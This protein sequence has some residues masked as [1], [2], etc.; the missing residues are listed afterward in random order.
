MDKTPVRYTGNL[1]S[2]PNTPTKKYMN[3][4]EMT[5]RCQACKEMRP[6][7]KIS[8]LTYP[9]KDLKNAEVNYK[10]CNDKPECLEKAHKVALED[11]LN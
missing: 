1:G 11:L 10:Y 4:S 7:D 5:W 3:L 6:D 2:I 9:L 8:V